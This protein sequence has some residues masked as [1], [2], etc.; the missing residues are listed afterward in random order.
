M[1][2]VVATIEPLFDRLIIFWS[3]RRSPHKVMPTFRDRS[4]EMCQ[5]SNYAFHLTVTDM[6]SRSGT[7]TRAKKQN[8]MTKTIM[9]KVQINIY[10]G[11]FSLIKKK[12]SSTTETERHRCDKRNS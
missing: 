8:L 9:R 7:L 10:P 12:C 1:A 3:D 4:V 5:V 2:G 6:P 11:D